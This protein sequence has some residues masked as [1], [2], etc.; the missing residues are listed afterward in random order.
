MNAVVLLS[1]IVGGGYLDWERTS[2]ILDEIGDRELEGR[3]IEACRKQLEFGKEV[4]PVG[5]LYDVIAQ[6]V[7]EKLDVDVEVYANYLDT[8]FTCYDRDEVLERV[9]EKTME[10]E[11]VLEDPTIRFFLGQVGID[12]DRAR[13]AVVEVELLKEQAE[14]FFGKDIFDEED[15]TDLAVLIYKDNWDE[16]EELIRDRVPDLKSVEE[17]LSKIG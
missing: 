12:T 4:D 7:N 15:L 11:E 9:A 5:T 3:F 6:V 1:D 17:F 16:V 14:E 13:S 2:E 10:D 8:S